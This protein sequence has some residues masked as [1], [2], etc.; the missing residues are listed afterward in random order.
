LV[1]GGGGG[2]GVDFKQ[3]VNVYVYRLESAR[4]VIL[5]TGFYNYYRQIMGGN[6]GNN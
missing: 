1:K 3:L 5:D 6:D 2:G 4:I